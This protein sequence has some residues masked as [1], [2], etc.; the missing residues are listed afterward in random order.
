MPATP[1]QSA[2]PLRPQTPI[3]NRP[4]ARVA[5]S[6]SSEVARSCRE[7]CVWCRSDLRLWWA[8]DGKLIVPC[9]SFYLSGKFRVTSPKQRNLASVTALTLTKSLMLTFWEHSHFLYIC[10]CLT[11]CLGIKNFSCKKAEMLFSSNGNYV[12]WAV[13]HGQK[14]IIDRRDLR[15]LMSL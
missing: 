5:N 3:P 15:L 4:R 8:A 2:S 10:K 14:V 9:L 1:N 12:T 6:V 13:G 7:L 11:I